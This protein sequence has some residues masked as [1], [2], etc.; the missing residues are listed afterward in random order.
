MGLLVV[1]VFFLFR[2]FLVLYLNWMLCVHNAKL[3]W[4]SVA[5]Q[6]M[7]KKGE[8]E[9][10]GLSWVQAPMGR[11]AVSPSWSELP[12]C[13]PGMKCSGMPWAR[14]SPLECCSGKHVGNY[15]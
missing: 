13:K 14:L 11:F 9:M 6:T 2:F 7:G 10:S 8:K 5:L 3:P 12:M 1:L 4:L 15:S